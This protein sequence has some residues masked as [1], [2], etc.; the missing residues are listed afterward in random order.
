M[1]A[2]VGIEIPYSLAAPERRLD[3]VHHTLGRRAKYPKLVTKAE[4]CKSHLHSGGAIGV[5][6][7]VEELREK[8]MRRIRNAALLVSKAAITT[9]ISRVLLY[10]ALIR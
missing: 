6:A 9:G 1:A 10:I 7:I 5:I 8:Q 2:W 3:F 4:H